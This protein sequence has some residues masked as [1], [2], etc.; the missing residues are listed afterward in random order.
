[1]EPWRELK[2]GPYKGWTEDTR[3]KG[4][5]WA[6]KWVRPFEGHEGQFLTIEICVYPCEH[7]RLRWFECEHR[8]EIWQGH[9]DGYDAGTAMPLKQSGPGEHRDA[10]LNDGPAS[11][12]WPTDADIRNELVRIRE[13][14]DWNGDW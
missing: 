2:P 6:R 13:P 3:Q 7:H 9:P 10:S 5:A 14:H 4:Q 11:E 1:M 8:F 12:P